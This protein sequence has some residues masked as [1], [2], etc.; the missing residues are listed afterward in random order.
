MTLLEAAA[1]G[2]PVVSTD[3]G[4]VRDLIREGETGYLVAAGDVDGLTERV[5]RLLG[6]AA[7]RERM[8]QA[9]AARARR[10][11]ALERMVRDYENLFATVAGEA[12]S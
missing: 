11:F 6:D 1:S 3:V 2:V 9:A 12:A 10:D 4:S 7:L 8:G 5:G